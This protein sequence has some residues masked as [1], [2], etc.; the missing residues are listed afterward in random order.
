MHVGANFA[1]FSR[2]MRKACDQMLAEVASASHSRP[3]ISCARRWV[4]ANDAIDLRHVQYSTFFAQRQLRSCDTDCD[5]FTCP[6]IP[7]LHRPHA[8]PVTR[9]HETLGTCI[10]TPTSP[11]V[12][13]SRTAPLAPNE[14]HLLRTVRV[15]RREQ[16]E[17][18]IR[19]EQ[20]RHGGVLEAIEQLAAW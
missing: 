9:W 2:P 18:A 19:V 16:H 4:N 13:L 7:A 11:S 15:G 1:T 8:N 14:H 17:V 6:N 5:I 12:A 20:T 10:A 3:S